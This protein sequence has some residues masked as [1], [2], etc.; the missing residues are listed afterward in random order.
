MNGHHSVHPLDCAALRCHSRPGSVAGGFGIRLV[1]VGFHYP[2][3]PTLFTGV[4]FSIN[5]NSRICLVGPNGIGKSTL[6]KIV[7]E[8]RDTWLSAVSAVCGGLRAR[9]C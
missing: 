2:N 6:L 3:A 4:E 1:G 7:Y 8:V 9:V 5:Q